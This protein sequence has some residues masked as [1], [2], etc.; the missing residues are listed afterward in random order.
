MAPHP[1]SVERSFH[2]RCTYRWPRI[3]Y[4]FR[5]L[6]RLSDRLTDTPSCPR[7]I[8]EHRGCCCTAH[9]RNKPGRSVP[10]SKHWLRSRLRNKAVPLGHNP[11]NSLCRRRRRSK[12]CR[13]GGWK[14]DI[15]MDTSCFRSCTG[16]WCCKADSVCMPRGTSHPRRHSGH[17]C[18]LRSRVGRCR[19]KRRRCCFGRR[20][21]RSRLRCSTAD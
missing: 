5:R 7:C 11:R 2:S 3:H 19:R 8:D 9:R 14:L 17:S 13:R 12:P 6:D 1:R 15:R 10:Q 20:W 18:F 21:G 16:C 4:G